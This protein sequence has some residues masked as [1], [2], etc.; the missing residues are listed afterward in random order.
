MFGKITHAIGRWYEI[1]GRRHWFRSQWEYGFARYLDDLGVAWEYEKNTFPIL[2]NGIKTT[3]TPD[4]FLTDFKKYVEVKGYWRDKY[5][6]K[7]QAFAAAYPD[8][9]IEVWDKEKLIQHGIVNKK[10]YL[11]LGL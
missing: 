6:E 7:A 2:V 4:F 10:G 5:I 9:V 8:V 11:T 1:N 3:Y